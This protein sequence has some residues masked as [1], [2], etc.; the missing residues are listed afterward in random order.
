MPRQTALPPTIAPRLLGRE[1]S[2]AYACLSPNT[3]DILVEG[4]MMPKPRILGANRRAW[5]VR[6]LDAAIDALPHDGEP[7]QAADEGWED[8][9]CHVNSRH[10]SSAIGSRL[11]SPYDH[12]AEPRR[13]F[14]PL[15]SRAWS[16]S[17]PS[18]L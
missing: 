16:P 6:E 17:R 18:A 14:R 7:A 13:A 4:N 5:D 15:T 2:A 1:A 11:C 8:I 10:T 9:S 3:F 12:R